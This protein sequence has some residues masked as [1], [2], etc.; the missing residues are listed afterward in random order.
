VRRTLAVTAAAGLLALGCSGGEEEILDLQATPGADSEPIDEPA[1]PEP[2]VEETEESAEQPEPEDPYAVPDEIDEDYVERV[3]NAILEV[4]DE[5]LRG[6]LHQERGRALPEEL[7]ALHFATTSGIQRVEGLEEYQLYIDD[8]AAR[9]ALRTPDELGHS[10]FEV[11]E[12]IHAEPESCILAIG[13][14][15]RAELLNDEPPLGL[16]VFSL[17]RIDESQERSQG[18]PTP[19]QWRDNRGLSDAVNPDEWRDLDYDTAFDH[20]CEAL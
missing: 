15:D 9:G 8:P 20:T 19:W 6:T 14:W 5:V 16:S 4:Q 2:E 3:I 17:S 10:R 11:E 12:V 1:D 13:D 18:N 7:T